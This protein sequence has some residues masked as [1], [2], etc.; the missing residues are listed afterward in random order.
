MTHASVHLTPI[1]SL[2]PW[3][4]NARTHSRKQIRQIADSI[5]T[6]GFTNPVLIDATGNILAGHGRVEA[7]K[8]I[9]MVEV[10]CL[11]IEHLSPAQKRAY[12]LAD[13]KLALNASWDEDLLADELKQ[14]LATDLGFDLSVTGFEIAEIDTL[15]D[16]LEPQEDGDPRDDALPP[17]AQSSRCRAGDIWRLGPHRLVCGSALD[18]DTVEALMDGERARMVFADPPYNVP[19]DGHVGGSGAIRHREFAMASG[20]MSSAEFTPFLRAAFRNLAD[21]SHDGRSTSS[22]WTGGTCRRCRPRPTVSIASSR[23]S[24]SG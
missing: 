5:K 2:R 7:A 1:A 23:T 9:G 8:L 18:R 19:I 13:N 12:V 24:V 6:F 17:L 4:R 21:F 11:R 14:L 10:P 15:I 20:E 16:G 22:A 3:A